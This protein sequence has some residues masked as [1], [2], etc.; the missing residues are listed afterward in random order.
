M[1]GK[2]NKV[3]LNKKIIASPIMIVRPNDNVL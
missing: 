1:I 3:I 2:G